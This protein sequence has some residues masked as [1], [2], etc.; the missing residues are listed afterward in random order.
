M[1]QYAKSTDFQM[2]MTLYYLRISTGFLCPI[3]PAPVELY[4]A[5]LI[6]KY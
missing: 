3:L 1:G 5:L 4:L 6:S 2:E